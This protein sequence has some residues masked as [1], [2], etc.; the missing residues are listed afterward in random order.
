MATQKRR[1]LSEDEKSDVRRLRELLDERKKSEGMTQESLAALCDWS[2]QSAVQGFLSERTPIN[3]DAALRFSKAFNV[4]MEA[5]SPRLAAKAI[6]LFGATQAAN[7]RPKTIDGLIESLHDDINNVDN[8]ARMAIAE[9]VKAYKDNPTEGARIA[10]SILA[11]L[12]KL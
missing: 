5:I 11:V 12:G 7:E 10:R 3:L 1:Q 6:E 9:F 2:G 4:P 8:D